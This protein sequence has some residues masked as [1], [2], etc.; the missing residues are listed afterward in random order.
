M[1]T[2]NGSLLR[3]YSGMRGRANGKAGARVSEACFGSERYGE[4]LREGSS[5]GFISGENLSLLAKDE[6]LRTLRNAVNGIENPSAIY[7][8]QRILLPVRHEQV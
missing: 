2:G 8:G 3:G 6:Y 1:L 5:Y 4:S 7:A